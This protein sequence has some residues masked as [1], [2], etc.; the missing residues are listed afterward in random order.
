MRTIS[1]NHKP[2]KNTTNKETNKHKNK[3]CVSI[4]TRTQQHKKQ[5][6][7]NTNKHFVSFQKNKK[8]TYNNQTPKEKNTTTLKQ[9]KN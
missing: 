3:E 7:Q 2:S 9:N 5:Q 8:Q 1:N 6:P 4:Q